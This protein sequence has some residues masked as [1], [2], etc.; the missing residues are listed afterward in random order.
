MI[1]GPWSICPWNENY[2]FTFAAR[3]EYWTVV[4]TAVKF[5][6]PQQCHI[7]YECF[8]GWIKTKAT[9]ILSSQVQ[10]FSSLLPPPSQE[11][12]Q[13][14]FSPNCPSLWNCAAPGTLWI[15]LRTAFTQKKSKLFSPPHPPPH[16]HPAVIPELKSR[17]RECTWMWSLP[18]FTGRFTPQRFLGC[19]LCARHTTVN[20]P[21][22][23]FSKSDTACTPINTQCIPILTLR[24]CQEQENVSVG[25]FFYN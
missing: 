18:P 12:F 21:H 4:K 3:V 16:T 6:A 14:P 11:T 24:K 22:S 5:F 17:R 13:I 10:C 9:E 25:N 23:H 7:Q 8:Y 2:F 15:C 20:K 1:L 19:L